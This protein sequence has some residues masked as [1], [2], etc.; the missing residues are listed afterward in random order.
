MTTSAGVAEAVA[1][2]PPSEVGGDRS[3]IAEMLA[4]RAALNAAFFA[5]ESQR[6]AELCATMAD[7]FVR[8]GRLIAVGASPAARSDARHVAVEFMHPVI[9]GKRALPAIGLTGLI[10]GAVNR[11]AALARQD[12]IVMCFGGDEGLEAALSESL[13]LCRRRGCLTIAFESLGAEVELEPP[14]DDPFARQESIET[15]YH[16]LW[17]LVH[18]FF[19]HGT[20]TASPENHPGG[21]A[22]LYPFLAGAPTD[23][24]AILRDVSASVVAKARDVNALRGRMLDDR[25]AAI[26]TEA[27]R[28][29]ARRLASGGSV[30]AFG[31]GGSATDA[32]D[33]VADLRCPPRHMAGGL[34]P[35]RAL[36]LTDDVSIVTALANDVSVDVIYA[37]QIAALAGPEDI[38]VAFST[39]GS[40]R[41]V[42]AALD[43]ARRRGSLTVA[44]TG[45]DGGQIAHDGHAEHVINAPSQ[46]I[47]RIQEAHATG[48]HILRTLIG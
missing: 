35:R 41:N 42:I 4:T 13:A 25:G 20:T 33:L 30:F 14:S 12:D 47:P 43:E 8:G 16:V 7:R 5:A 1:N 37:R 32:M 3:P 6:I 19:E 38:A 2:T 36:D 26:L 48:Y 11:L 39:S 21:S 29:V 23:R 40:S 9:V 22:F 27:A 24:A 44:F 45:Y 46:H 31:N 34:S 17:E 10:D 28:D 18:V 15:L